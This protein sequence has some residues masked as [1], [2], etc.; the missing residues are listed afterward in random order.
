V[1]ARA[2]T[3]D[4]IYGDNF[5]GFAQAACDAGLAVDSST[6][7]DYALAIDLCTQTTEDSFTPGLLSATLTQADGVSLPAT[8]YSIQSAFGDNN[9]PLFGSNLIVLSTGSAVNVGQGGY[10]SYEPGFD[11]GSTSAMPADWLAA[12]S[13]VVPT[14]PGCPALTGETTA[15]DSIM[16]TLRVRV[17][18]NAR[19]FSVGTNFFSADYPEW[20]CSPYNDMFLV[21]LDSTYAGA[22]ANPSDKNLA[23][24]FTSDSQVY[25]VGVNLAFGNTGLFTQCVDSLTGCSDGIEGSTTTCLSTSGLAGTGMGVAENICGAANTVGGATGWLTTRGNVVPGETIALRIAIWDT[26]DGGLDSL[27]LL[28]NFQ[29][30]ANPIT[31]GTTLQ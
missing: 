31:P 29:S 5:Q 18:N 21:L 17:P 19:S 25:T 11:T 12:H 1:L 3:Q 20:V 22:S 30:S 8:Q 28:D 23:Q 24:Y 27:V 2:V 9:L 10:R 7:S 15:H 14:A 26:S 4:E 16:L 13:G 6:A